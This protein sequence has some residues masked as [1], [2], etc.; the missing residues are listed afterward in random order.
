[1]DSGISDMAQVTRVTFEGMTFG[2]KL[3]KGGVGVLQN[4]CVLLMHEWKKADE[5]R[6]NSLGGMVDKKTI[7]KMG[8]TQFV[9]IDSTKIKEFMELCEKY[10]VPVMQMESFKEGKQISTHFAYPGQKATNLNAVMEIIRSMTSEDIQKTKNKTKEEADKESAEINRTET[11]DEC[12]E[13][14]GV[15]IPPKEFKEKFLEKY[16]DESYLFKTGT[17]KK[18]I[19]KE[20]TAAIV[21]QEKKDKAR[22]EGHT[23]IFFNRSQEVGRATLNGEKYVKVQVPDNKNLVMWF[24]EKDIIP[25]GDGQFS[26]VIPKN[27]M[28]TFTD[29][30]TNTTETL[31]FDVAMK[32]YAQKNPTQK[33][34]TKTK[35]TTRALPDKGMGSMR[36]RR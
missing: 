15:A 24:K 35:A 10:N 32:K 4:F 29:R 14:L 7:K 1:M 16:P 21:R 34:A 6:L 18:T 33:S 5:K 20:V 31:R 23:E 8:D 28:M 22:S 13:E 36:N 3:I 30:A 11:A 2:V 12:A 26:A 9:K 27:G 19:D 17:Q 25:R